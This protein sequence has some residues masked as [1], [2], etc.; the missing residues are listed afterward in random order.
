MLYSNPIP[1]MIVQDL[2]DEQRERLRRVLDGM[3]RERSRGSGPV[4][5]TNVVHIGIGT[6]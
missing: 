5:L 1:G 2:T 4:V 6:R 3:L